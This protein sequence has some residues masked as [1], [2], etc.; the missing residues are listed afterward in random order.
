MLVEAA[1]DTGFQVD[2][3]RSE[4]CQV[5]PIGPELIGP[6]HSAK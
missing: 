3:N 6:Q 1:R 4:I 5:L 2:P